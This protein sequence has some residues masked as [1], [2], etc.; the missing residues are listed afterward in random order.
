[1]DLKAIV[2]DIDGTLLNDQKVITPRT[3]ESLLRAQEAG[4][5]LVLASGRPL[6]AMLKFSKELK[7]EHYHGLLL[8]NN[9]A[10]VTD[11]ATDEMLFSQSI[12]EEIGSALL[13]H[14]EQF[15]VKP[16]IAHKD[17]MYVNNVYDCM[18]TAPPHGLRNIIEYES[19][20]GDF[21]LC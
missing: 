1:M 19:R 2:L 14:L 9:G 15:E 17:Y 3:R 10:C 13:T 16:M 11:C 6:P 21:K 8:S 18:I 4:V 20:S 7:M 12:S 5:K